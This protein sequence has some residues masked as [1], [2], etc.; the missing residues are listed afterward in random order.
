MVDMIV[1]SIEELRYRYEIINE[2][3][4]KMVSHTHP[5]SRNGN[6]LQCSIFKMLND[7]LSE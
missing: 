5:I 2:I 4:S 3:F 7:R 6:L 1:S